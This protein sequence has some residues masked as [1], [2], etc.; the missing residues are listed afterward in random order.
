MHGSLIIF[1]N[2]SLKNNS[3]F[4]VIFLCLILKCES[5]VT[6][7]FYD[8]LFSYDNYESSYNWFECRGKV[9]GILFI[10]LLLAFC[11]LCILK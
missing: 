3:K 7:K 6:L 8:V 2:K 9:I 1:K 4:S 5:L 10:M 11:T